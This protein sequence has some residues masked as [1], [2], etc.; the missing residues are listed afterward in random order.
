MKKIKAYVDYN[1]WEKIR[2]YQMFDVVEIIPQ[3][4]NDEKV[5]NII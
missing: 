4:Y 5:I 2:Y 1:E 3:Y